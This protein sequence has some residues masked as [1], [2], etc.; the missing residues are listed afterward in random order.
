MWDTK[1]FLGGELWYVHMQQLAVYVHSISATIC[2]TLLEV[3]CSLWYCS[4]I[5][6]PVPTKAA[7]AKKVR[8]GITLGFM[9]LCFIV[10]N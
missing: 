10:L 3:I 6:F 4:I 2:D 7:K 9:A 5:S 8:L 1:T